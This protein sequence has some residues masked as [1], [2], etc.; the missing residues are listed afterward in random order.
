M[1]LSHSVSGALRT[2]SYWVANG[3]L[4]LPLL[5]GIDYRCILSEEPSALEQIYAIFANVLE[6][7]DDGQVLNAKYAEQRAAQWL[8]RYMDPTFEIV[9]ELAYWEVALYEPPPRIDLA[10][11]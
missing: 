7:D 2:F 5:D 10:R 8:R 11:S 9:P 1:K 4:G 3:T 6:F